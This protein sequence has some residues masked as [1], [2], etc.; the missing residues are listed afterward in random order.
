MIFLTQNSMISVT[1][2]INTKRKLKHHLN[3][4]FTISIF[5]LFTQE[6]IA[7][8]IKFLAASKIDSENT[9]ISK[10]N[11]KKKHKSYNSLI[12]EN[13][14]I[15]EYLK[16]IGYLLNTND[17]V[18]KKKSTYV[19]YF[20]LNQK[21][22]TIVLHI[23]DDIY[24]YV[25]KYNPFKNTI[26]IPVSELKNL[27]TGTSKQLAIKGK[28]FSEV[29]L[30]NII[31]KEKNITA[32]LIVKKTKKRNIDK[33]FIKGYEEFPK[34]FLKNYFRINNNTIF[35]EEKISEISE[36]TKNLNFVEEIKKPEVLFKQDSTIL[37]I[38]VKKKNNNSFDA[39]V[40]FASEENGD[41]L[42][43]GNIDLKL[44]NILNSGEKLELFWNS[45]GQERQEFKFKIEKPYI[46]NS[47]ISPE[48]E[49][50]IYKQDSSFV[51]TK[52]NTF[53]NYSI[54]NKNRLALNYSSESSNNLIETNNNT[55]SFSN[56]FLGFSY[57]YKIPSNNLLLN[58]KLVI[59]ITP[60]FGNRKSN[61]T[62]TQQ[63]KII[64]NTSYLFEVSTRNNIYVKNKTGYLDSASPLN[65]E[66][67]RIGGANSIRGFNEQSIF[68]QSFTYFNT[69]YRYLTS[70]SSY[71]YSILDFGQFKINKK[72]NS[73][74]S[75][76]L[77]YLFST[78]NYK[79][80]IATAIGKTG[81]D[82]FDFNNSKIII[83]WINYF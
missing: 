26:K 32:D 13:K 28:V 8:E 57:E 74:L 78:K 36:I 34:S 10:I 44:N 62:S 72:T 29:K 43:N 68:T 69:E 4:I 77:G 18:I 56:F 38:Y 7:Q 2:E 63:F 81:S 33:T 6:Y 70:K 22:D 61:N 76:G 66:L 14:K 50:S 31:F 83:S 24:T 65:N 40:N 73:I 15:S 47:K 54:N 3:L 55:D 64:T 60:S 23:K 75:L 71:L 35:N 80:N 53:F 21:I 12:L 39:L 45:I 1:F 46:F 17:S 37:Y 48:I 20:S 59:N 11:Y 30:G 27:M 19:S 67:F 58:N 51:N 41:L 52:L 49:F 42:F 5:L 82:N 16:S 79:V 25:E 9:I